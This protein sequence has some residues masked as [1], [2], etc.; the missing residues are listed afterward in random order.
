MQYI[1][2]LM[3][4]LLLANNRLIAKNQYNFSR[5]SRD[6][7]RGLNASVWASIT[8]LFVIMLLA[9]SCWIEGL[10]CELLCGFFAGLVFLKT[11]IFVKKKGSWF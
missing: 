4:N 5:S 9:L 3:K 8:K 1:I 10:F 6:Q 11:F 2:V 7:G